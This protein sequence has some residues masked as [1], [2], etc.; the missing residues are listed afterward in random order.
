MQTDYKREMRMKKRFRI[1][2][3]CMELIICSVMFL[4]PEKRASAA[5]KYWLV[6]SYESCELYLKQNEIVIKGKF[7]KCTSRNNYWKEKGK[8]VKYKSRKI[9]LSK[10]CKISEIA[11]IEYVYHYDQYISEKEISPWENAR[12]IRTGIVIKN[13]KV[14]KISFSA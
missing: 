8:K 5:A 12:S 2:L 14:A 11:D 13:G 10:N 1:F 9:K 3:L 6:G 7:I 4:V